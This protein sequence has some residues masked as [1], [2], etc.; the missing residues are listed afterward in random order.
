MPEPDPRDRLHA[1]LILVMIAV[2][3]VGGFVAGMLR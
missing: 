3:A 2:A 1:A